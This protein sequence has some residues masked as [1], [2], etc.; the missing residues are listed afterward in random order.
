[1]LVEQ[2][3]NKIDRSKRQKG[4]AMPV[5]CCML[6]QLNRSFSFLMN[7]SDCELTSAVCLIR[8]VTAVIVRVTDVGVRYTASVVARKLVR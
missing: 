4:N 5:M 8:K 6:P 1:M 7:V 3:Y 2:P